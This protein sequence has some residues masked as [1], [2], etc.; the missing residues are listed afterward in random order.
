VRR[1]DLVQQLVGRLGL[2]DHLDPGLLQ[3]PDKSLAGDHR[4]LG[5]D[6]AHRI[7]AR[8]F[9]GFRSSQPPS[10]PMRSAT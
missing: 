6:Y 7:S 1:G 3:Q 4:V 9:V 5:D 8:R 10:A 2:G